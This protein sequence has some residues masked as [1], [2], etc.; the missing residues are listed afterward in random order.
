MERSYGY[1]VDVDDQ[2]P[3][4]RVAPI[5]PITPLTGDTSEE[6]EE[7][8]SKFDAFSVLSGHY[9]GN[10]FDATSVLIF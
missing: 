5:A 10:C 9:S 6:E 8:E 4:V 2:I 3:R 1:N 7:V